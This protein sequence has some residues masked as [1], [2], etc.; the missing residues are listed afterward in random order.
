MSFPGVSPGLATDHLPTSS[1]EIRMQGF[2]SSV[3]PLWLRVYMCVKVKVNFSLEQN[4][5]AQKGSRSVA[6][7]FL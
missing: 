2:S 5:K 4:M 6:L 7:I 1:A 3:H